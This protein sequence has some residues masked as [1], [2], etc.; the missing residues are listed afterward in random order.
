M[1]NPTT[2]K[3]SQFTNPIHLDSFMPISFPNPTLGFESQFTNPI[4]LDNIMPISFPNPT[5]DYNSQFTTSLLLGGSPTFNI[6]PDMKPGSNPTLE[7]KY[8]EQ[9]VAPFPTTDAAPGSLIPQFKNQ[10]MLAS[11]LLNKGINA[12]GNLIG[13]LTGNLSIGN[14][15]QAINQ[16]NKLSTPYSTLAFDQLKPIPGVKYS[17]FRSRVRLF[18]NKANKDSEEN[19]LD[20]DKNKNVAAALQSLTANGASALLRGSYRAGAYAAADISPAGAYSLFNV[21]QRYGTGEQDSPGALRKDF[22]ARTNITTRWSKLKGE[23]QPT[24]NPLEIANPFRGDKVNAVDYQRDAKLKSAYRWKPKGKGKFGQIL[25]AVTD[26]LGV[27]TTQDFI[28]FY[29]TGPTIQPG[30]DQKDDII[31]FRAIITN[32]D[33][34]FSADWSS[35]QMVGRADPN[36]QYGSYTRA[37]SLTF[38]VYAT[39]RDELKP[40]YRKLNA[41]ASYTAPIYDGETIAMIGP[42]MRLTVGDIH[43]Q[44]PIVLTSVTFTYAM[45]APWEIN[46]EDDPHMMQ[47]PQKVSVSCQFNI[48]ANDIPQNNGRILSLARKYSDGKAIRGGHNW[49]SDFKDSIPDIPDVTNTADDTTNNSDTGTTKIKSP[50][51]TKTLQDRIVDAY[52]YNAFG[53]GRPR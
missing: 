38:D 32:F 2:G 17:D 19:F 49:L 23:F 9:F 46:I 31:A 35:V 5:L 20:R 10:E 15:A 53:D 41:L 42:W 1:S 36:Y 11:A 7:E 39:D 14:I 12:A 8:R 6:L 27:G 48:I 33:D 28:K 50:E 34:S 4:H 26:F 43:N 44:Q 18:T 25:G 37:G 40:I 13:G 22:T 45:D 30:G 21:R 29:F 51:K 3:L 24:R 52:A 47:T 16:G